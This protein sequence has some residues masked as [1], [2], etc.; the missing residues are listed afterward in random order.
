MADAQAQV[1][2]QMR[3]A[4]H[5]ARQTVRAPWAQALARYG[6]ACKGVVYLVMGALALAAAFGVRG[7]ATTNRQ[8]ALLALYRQPLGRWLLAVV[9]VGFVGYALW[10]LL[11][12]LLDLDGDGHD[13]QGVL[14]RLGYA[15]VG[16]SYLALAVGTFKLFADLGGLGESSDQTARDW[17]ARLLNLPFGVEMVVLGGLV[18]AGIAVALGY[19]AISGR[20]MVYFKRGK[21]TPT[22]ERAV[23]LL[24]RLG[25]L[26][27]GVVFGI[28]A[29]FLI[30]AA[31][32]HNPSEA[33]GL[34]GALQ[35]LAQE[36]FGPLLL[37]AVALGLM[38]YGVYSFAEARYRRLAGK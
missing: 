30:V 29:L 22:R 20:F 38:I 35:Q 25:L 14:K 33:K 2:H 32:H 11:L 27:L 18:L 31:L 8:G 5:S 1:T 12:A 6:Y 24:G 17:T 19:Q 26:A 28:V 16:I 34:G 21:M 10:S 36:P 37:A 7:G 4:E 15:A 23:L 3:E 9:A 13:A